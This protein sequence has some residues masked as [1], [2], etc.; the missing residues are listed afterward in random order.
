MSVFALLLWALLRG[1]LGGPVQRAAWFEGVNP[2]QTN[3]EGYGVS[4]HDSFYRLPVSL[5]APG[6]LVA[7]ELLR[8]VPH[9]RPLP[10]ELMAL[11]LPTPRPHQSVQETGARAVEVWCGLD[12]VSVCVDRFQLSAWTVPSLFRLGSCEASSVTPRFLFFRFRLTECGGEAKVVGGQL[13][14]TYSLWYTPPPQ[15][16]IIRVLPLNLPIQCLYDRFHYSYQV[17]FR[18]QVQHTTLIK[19]IRSKRSYS[20]TVCN[21]QGEPIP[22]G[23]WFFLGEPVY[24]VAQTGV[25]LA[26]ERLYVD[27]CYATSSKDPSSMPKVDIITNYGCMVDSNRE[28]SSS[29]FLSGVGSVLKFSVDAFLFRAVSQVLYLH[30]SMSVGFSASPSSKS[31]SYNE[32]AGRWEELEA[33][34]SVCA[35]CDSMCTDMQDSIRNTVSSPGWLIGQRAE[36]KPRMQVT[37]FQAEEVR[38]RLDHEER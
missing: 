21:A 16:Y 12:Q 28:G 8:P 9:K 11:L 30:C 2:A 33:S 1:T 6:P 13:V 5:H 18:P 29:L 20:L 17:G 35:C 27:A 4:P 14:Y 36:E 32:T 15:G 31:C 25:L 38:Q 7:R 3:Q 37:S 24:F 23:H 19:S 34:A 10:A 22:P 26:G